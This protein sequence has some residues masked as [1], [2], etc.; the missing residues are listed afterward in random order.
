MGVVC[1]TPGIEYYHG[2]RNTGKTV[3]IISLPCA[4][5]LEL[6]VFPRLSL[7]LTDVGGIVAG[8]VKQ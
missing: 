7:R 6:Q 1:S 4:F 5:L 8:Q 3:S 2:I